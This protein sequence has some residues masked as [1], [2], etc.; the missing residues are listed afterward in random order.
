[1]YFPPT[2]KEPKPFSASNPKKKERHYQMPYVSIEAKDV[3]F[4]LIDADC[5]VHRSSL[6]VLVDDQI[7]YVI[8]RPHLYEFLLF[9]ERR[10]F[11]GIY[12][13]MKR[14]HLEAIFSAINEYVL[15][16]SAEDCSIAD[17]LPT[18]YDEEQC[19]KTPNGLMKSMI[20]ESEHLELTPISRIWMID[21]EEGL[22]DFPQRKVLISKFTG[23]PR[24]R[25]LV[26][27]ILE[28]G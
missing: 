21:V 6:K 23:D 17:I 22:V 10:T 11:A 18:I 14:A 20:Y 12:S 2:I 15:E 9:L 25:G 4:T 7:Y 28:H 26:D 5:A 16:R 3:L 1:M 27:F 8:P 19:L 13:T 24:D